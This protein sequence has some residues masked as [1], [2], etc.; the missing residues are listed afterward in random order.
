MLSPGCPAVLFSDEAELLAC[1]ALDISR[2]R[3][4]DTVVV[5]VVLRKRWGNLTPAHGWRRCWQSRRDLRL[6]RCA[7]WRERGAV[8]GVLQRLSPGEARTLL[9][10][11]LR[12]VRCAAPAVAGIAV[13]QP[14]AGRSI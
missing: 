13:R 6:R 14:A 5:A 11:G 8:A 1:L 10:R 9:R 3:A 7:F 2:G 4:G 12:C